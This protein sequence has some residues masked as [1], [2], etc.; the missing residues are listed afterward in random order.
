V[1]NTNPS[2]IPAILELAKLWVNSN[3]A[4]APNAEKLFRGAQCYKGNEPLEEAQKGL[5][6]AFY[7][8][9]KMKE[10]LMQSEYLKQTWPQNGQYRQLNEMT[11]AVLSRAGNTKA[12]APIK[13]AMATCNE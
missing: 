11:R 13:V 8:Q 9:G 4:L 1:L 6:F 2:H 10:A 12:L 7:Y 5:F 3:P